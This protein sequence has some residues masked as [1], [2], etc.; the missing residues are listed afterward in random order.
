V[1]E[2]EHMSSCQSVGGQHSSGG[3]LHNDNTAAWKAE[4]AVADVKTS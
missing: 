2:I 1:V 4:A 3:A